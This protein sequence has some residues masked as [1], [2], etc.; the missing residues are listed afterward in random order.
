[1]ERGPLCL[2]DAADWCL[3]ASRVDFTLTVVYSMVILVTPVLIEGHQGAWHRLPPRDPA[4]AA[5]P[6]GGPLAA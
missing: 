3:A 6:V 4:L 1:V 2:N 5:K